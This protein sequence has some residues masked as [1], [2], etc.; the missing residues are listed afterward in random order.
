MLIECLG[1]VLVIAI[2]VIV[3]AAVDAWIGVPMIAEDEV[4]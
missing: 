4:E 3:V 2:V 1:V